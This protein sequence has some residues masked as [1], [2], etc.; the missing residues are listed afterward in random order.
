MRD[1]KRIDEI[2]QVL[3]NIWIKN[4]D[5]RFF[6][7]IYILQNRFSTENNNNEYKISDD[8]FYLEDDKFLNFLKK[9]K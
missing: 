3:K 9:F 5:T 2:L 8:F 4:P 7:L 6:Q 1:P